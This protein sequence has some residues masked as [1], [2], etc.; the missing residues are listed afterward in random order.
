MDAKKN[1]NKGSKDY[2]VGVLI[3]YH[4]LYWSWLLF[5]FPPSKTESCKERLLSSK[6]S[7]GQPF[8]LKHIAISFPKKI[9]LEELYIE[10]QSRDTL[11]YAGELSIDTDLFA[12]LK[13]R[14]QLNDV[15]LDNWKIIISRPSDS[16]TFN[17]D[18]I[19][20]A[21]NTESTDVP[22]TTAVPWRFDIKNV[23]LTRCTPDLSRRLARK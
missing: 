9:V 11:L 18:F 4:F 16:E 5:R 6:K 12:L 21:F 7:S 3:T 15:S 14:I 13:R 1:S 23:K 10:D 2:R 22:D 8:S 20:A 19:P 17:Y